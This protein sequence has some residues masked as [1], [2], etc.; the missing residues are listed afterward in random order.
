MQRG[1][2]PRPCLRASSSQINLRASR[3]S[4]AIVQQIHLEMLYLLPQM[5]IK[6]HFLWNKM[7]QKC[8]PTCFYAHKLAAS[9]SVLLPSQ[10]NKNVIVVRGFGRNPS[11]FLSIVW[12][13]LIR[14]KFGNVNNT[15][16]LFFCICSGALTACPSYFCISDL[17][18]CNSRNILCFWENCCQSG[19]CRVWT[20]FS[21]VYFWGAIKHG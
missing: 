4:L 16:V 21:Y 6:T 1:E 14:L 3:R 12:S 8:T 9:W 20:S 7:R 19:R 5:R 10:L 18:C 15:T 17:D 11:C 13:F 2:E